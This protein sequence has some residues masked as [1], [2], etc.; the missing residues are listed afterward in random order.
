MP[1]LLFCKVPVMDVVWRPC[2]DSRHVMVPYKFYYLLFNNVPITGR[3][4]LAVSWCTG[5]PSCVPALWQN[6]YCCCCCSLQW[7]AHIVIDRDVMVGWLVV[8]WSHS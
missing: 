7:Q 1:K 4:M 6:K 8:G 3:T 5:V 2:S